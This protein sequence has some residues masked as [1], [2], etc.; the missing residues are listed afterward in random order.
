MAG[1]VNLTQTQM[2]AA[3]GVLLQ[4]AN[5]PSSSSYSQNGAFL[6]P[7]G[8]LQ[9]PDNTLNEAL[10]QVLLPLPMALIFISVLLMLAL[11][12]SW[13]NERQLSNCLTLSL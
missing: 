1:N 10:G 8:T 4:V 6:G 11:L 7:D 13:A 3:I 2:Q 5:F 12:Q 9:F